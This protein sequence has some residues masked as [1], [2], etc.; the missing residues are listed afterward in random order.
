MTGFGEIL[1]RHGVP[2]MRPGH[3]YGVTTKGS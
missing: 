2:I 1:M 3:E